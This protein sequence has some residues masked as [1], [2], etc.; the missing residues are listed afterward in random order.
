MPLSTE[1]Q[2]TLAFLKMAVVQLRKI[3]EEAPDIAA[4]ILLLAEQIEAEAAQI[5]R[6]A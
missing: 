6:R 4:R 5:E 3:A 1:E 2:H